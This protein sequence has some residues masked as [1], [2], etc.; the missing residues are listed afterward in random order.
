MR[1]SNEQRLKLARGGVLLF[2]L[3]LGWTAW[4]NAGLTPVSAET[5]APAS[6]LPHSGASQLPSSS[7]SL[8]LPLAPIRI[9]WFSHCDP[10]RDALGLY[11]ASDSACSPSGTATLAWL[12][13]QLR[14]MR[15]LSEGEQLQRAF[16]Q[17]LPACGALIAQGDRHSGWICLDAHGLYRVDLGGQDSGPRWQLQAAGGWLVVP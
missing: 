16:T 13:S 17:A 2:V 9:E 6:L 14:L 11:A 12:Q 3:T 7:A 8:A 5:P 15:V 1:D 10:A 4:Q